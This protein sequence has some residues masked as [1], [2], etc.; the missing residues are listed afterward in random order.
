M[1]TVISDFKKYWKYRYLMALFLPAIVYFV[2]FKYI[3]MGGL[4][5]AF[6]NFQTKRGFGPAHG[7]DWT[8]LRCCLSPLLSG[9]ALRIR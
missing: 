3:P 7:A 2:V 6:K 8:I 1:K 5:L 4:V 9:R